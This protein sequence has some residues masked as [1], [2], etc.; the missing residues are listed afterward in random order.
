MKLKCF[1][2]H[3]GD[4]TILYSI[5][6]LGAYTRGNSLDT[7]INKMPDEIRSFVAWCGQ[8]QNEK[9]IIVEIAEEKVSDLNIRDADTDA[10]FKCETWPMSKDEYIFLKNLS[11]KSAKD[12]LA[13]YNSV[14]DKDVSCLPVRKTFYGAAPRT[15]R[16]M[17]EH[18][19]N[20]NSYYFG[21]IGIQCNNDG[22]I[23][24]CRKRGFDLLEQQTDFL[25]NKPV[26]GGYNESWSLKKVLRRFIWH[27][28]IHAKAMCRMMSKT[29][30]ANSAPNIF[31]FDDLSIL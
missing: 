28:R 19:K 26:V 20:V 13:L 3:N 12:F 10:I 31:C 8:E 24:S 29:F 1:W 18:T 2:E 14:P 27:D 6:W 16:E 25:E 21:E 11:L 15:A 7:A 17:Y 23:F 5:D 9:Q 4:D 22:D 30:G